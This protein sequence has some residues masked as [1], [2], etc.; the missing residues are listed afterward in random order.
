MCVS[1]FADTGPVGR[2]Y[3]SD[4]ALLGTTPVGKP[5]CTAL[6][7]LRIVLDMN[8]GTLGFELDRKFLGVAFHNLLGNTLYPMVSAVYGGTTVTLTYLGEFTG[9]WFNI[10]I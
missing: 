6:L 1:F 9:N 2:T 8:T 5:Y 7:Q 4:R 3:P 10:V